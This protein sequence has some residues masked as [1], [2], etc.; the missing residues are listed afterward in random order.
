VLRYW[1][2]AALKYR[3]LCTLILED[4]TEK[5]KNYGYSLSRYG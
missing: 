2:F 5:G 3:P 1:N 4:S